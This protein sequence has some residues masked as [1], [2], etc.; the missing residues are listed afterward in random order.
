MHEDLVLSTRV[1]GYPFLK[2]SIQ[3]FST[4]VALCKRISTK[5]KIAHSKKPIDPFYF[6]LNICYICQIIISMYIQ[7][8]FPGNNFTSYL[9]IQYYFISSIYFD[10]NAHCLGSA[11]AGPQTLISILLFRLVFRK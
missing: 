6:F 2:S 4:E 8:E 10:A 1:L 3:F 5:T 9:I 11:K 7:N